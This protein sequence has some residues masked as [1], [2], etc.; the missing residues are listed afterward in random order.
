MTREELH[1]MRNW[2][3]EKIATGAE[4]P[5]A[6]YQYWKL[7]ETLD[8]ILAGMDAVE[9]TPLPAG[10]PESEPRPGNVGLRVVAGSQQDTVQ[11][12]PDIIPVRL[13]M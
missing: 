6:F 3:E 7:R 4:P 1:R 10:S 9:I 13:P 5:W 8:A 2:A 11:R 12:H